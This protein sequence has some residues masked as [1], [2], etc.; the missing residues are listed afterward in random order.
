MFSAF[1]LG[2]IIVIIA[3]VAAMILHYKVMKRRAAVDEGFFAL[4]NAEDSDEAAEKLSIA[5]AEYNAYISRFPARQMAY[6]LGLE[7][8]KL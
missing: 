8:E 4:K 6:M 2:S 5:I 3:S 1:G 7:Q